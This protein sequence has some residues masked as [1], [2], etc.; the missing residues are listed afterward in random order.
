MVRDRRVSLRCGIEP[1]FVTS[2]CL[3]VER[4]AMS[5]QLK[6]DLTLTQPGEASHLRGNDNR[7]VVAF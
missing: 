7:V 6:R 2:G 5:L 4:E 1:A 3:P